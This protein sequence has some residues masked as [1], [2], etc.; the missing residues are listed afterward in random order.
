MTSPDSSDAP[1]LDALGSATR[2]DIVRILGEGPRPVGEIAARLPVSRPAVSRHL[3]VLADARLVTC[4][5]AGTRSV[6]R[7]EATGFE[8]ARRWL[9]SFWDQALA[10]FAALAEG[11]EGGRHE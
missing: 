7:L 3:R 6:F 8:E 2:R 10:R 9:G 5:R 1:W 4:D 11:G